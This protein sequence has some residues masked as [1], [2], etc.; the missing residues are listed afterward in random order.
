MLLPADVARCRGIINRH[1]FLA[2]LCATCLRRKAWRE[3]HENSLAMTV[4]EPP[5][6]VKDCAHYIPPRKEPDHAR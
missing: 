2:L 6:H 5:K 1:G 4:V 3:D